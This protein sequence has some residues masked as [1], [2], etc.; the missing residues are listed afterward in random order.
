M[1]VV[2]VVVVVPDFIQY[3]PPLTSYPNFRSAR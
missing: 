3:G 1:Y 2:V